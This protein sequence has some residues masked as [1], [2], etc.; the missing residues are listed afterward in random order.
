MISHFTAF[1]YLWLAIVRAIPAILP[2]M[3]NA[4]SE[5]MMYKNHIKRSLLFHNYVC[6]SI[7]AS[8]NRYRN[9]S[10][11]EIASSSNL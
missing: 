4:N 5:N 9:N 2:R 10:Y 11:T 1:F 3:M 8:N 7:I 6:S